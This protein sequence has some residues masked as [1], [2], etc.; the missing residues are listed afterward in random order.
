MAITL[1]T[2][3]TIVRIAALVPLAALL[4]VDDPVARWMA[5]ALFVMAA[6]TD[7]VDGRLARAWN[8][9]TPLGRCLDPIADKLL[10]ATP[11]VILLGDG[12]APMLPVLVILVRELT[13]SGLR[14][15]LAGRGPALP[16]TVLA[17]WK[18]T[19]QM[20]ALSV[21]IVAA[22]LPYGATVGAALLWLAAA[23]TAITGAQYV[24][25]GLKE[26]ADPTR[27]EG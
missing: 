20:V 4:M 27:L 26:L 3:L 24:A 19:V 25:A 13:V 23:L 14:E 8:Q 6:L 12:A 16:V 1:P 5:L 21:L 2:W 17:K 9:V 22:A 10:V 18:T 7:W 11:L 15:A